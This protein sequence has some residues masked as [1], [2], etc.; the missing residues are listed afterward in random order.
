M[1][2]GE[3]IRLLLDDGIYFG[4]FLVFPLGSVLLLVTGGICAFGGQS[5]PTDVINFDGQ[6]ETCDYLP[7]YP[8]AKNYGATGGLIGNDIYVSCGGKMWKYGKTSDRC[9]KFGST[10]P[11]ATMI[12]SRRY[13]ASVVVNDKLLVAG[14]D[15]EN[16]EA[17]KSTEWIDPYTGS[18]ESGPDLPK[19]SYAPCLILV[20]STAAI[21]IGGWPNPQNKTWLYNFE[22]GYQGWLAGPQLNTGRYAHACSIVKDSADDSKTIVI[23]GILLR[24]IIAP[25][26]ELTFP[27]FPCHFSSRHIVAKIILKQSMK[28][29]FQINKLK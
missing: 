24:Y 15:N 20:N 23:A 2:Q 12:K 17:L 19:Q 9:Y 14:G 10:T 21:I 28:P 6:T 8:E 1:L 11:I 5:C 22:R 25:P 13:P 4:E 3:L 18:V 16:E 29:Y 7:N 27:K 26:R